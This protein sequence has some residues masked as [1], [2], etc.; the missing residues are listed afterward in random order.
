MSLPTYPSPTVFLKALYRRTLTR[1]ATAQSRYL[2]TD[3]K[4]VAWLLRVSSPQPIGQ[5]F[6]ALH[7]Q[8]CSLPTYCA[9]TRVSHRHTRAVRAESDLMHRNASDAAA[10]ASC[11]A[12]L[13]RGN[14][15]NNEQT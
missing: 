13:Q 15:N 1:V 4:T 12:T 5:W 6:A 11:N 10:R 3:S 7:A 9:V 14:Y 2:S 8:H